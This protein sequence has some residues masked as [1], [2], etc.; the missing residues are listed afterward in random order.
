M[1]DKILIRLATFTYIIC[2]FVVG[3]LLF[4]QMFV[5]AKFDS[6]QS[7]AMIVLIVFNFFVLGFKENIVRNNS[8]HLK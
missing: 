3:F 6:V 4:N 2:F 5:I 1:K 7:F 8:I